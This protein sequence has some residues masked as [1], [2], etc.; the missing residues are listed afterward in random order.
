MS[1][2]S[3]LK[4][5]AIYPRK[6]IYL[7]RSAFQVG[8]GHRRGYKLNWGYKVEGKKA[9]P[10]SHRSWPRAGATQERSTAKG[11]PSPTAPA[12]AQNVS[13]RTAGGER[14]VARCCHCA[15]KR[16]T[17]PYN[18]VPTYDADRAGKGEG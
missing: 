10:C 1:M 12:K 7:L 8:E 16:P 9:L 15:A 4:L 17:H 18:C 3:L 2:L 11:S 5:G 14:A 13:D 6:S